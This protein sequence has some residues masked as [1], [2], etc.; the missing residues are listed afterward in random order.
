MA[1]RGLSDSG[2]YLVDEGASVGAVACGNFAQ[3]DRRA[4]LLLG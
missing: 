3:N 1:M 2:Q 4:N